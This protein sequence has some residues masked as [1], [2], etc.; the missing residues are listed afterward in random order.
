M[1]FF[2][3]LI[4]N[5][6]TIITQHY[7]DFN[8]RVGKRS[9]WMFV[10]ANFIVSFVL[11]LIPVAGVFLGSIYSLAVL[12]PGLG[13]GIRRLHDIGKPGINLLFAL[14][15]IAGPIILIVWYCKDSEFGD[16]AYGPQAE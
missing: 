15:P 14:I 13:M 10:L 11:G 6:K 8:G 5:F 3:E 2:Q 12:V 7:A 9:F 1:N 4:E 16:N